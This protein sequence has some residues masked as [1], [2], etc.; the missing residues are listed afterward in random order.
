MGVAPE[1]VLSQVDAFFPEARAIGLLVGPSTSPESEAALTRAAGEVGVTLS[2]VRVSAAREVRGALHQAPALDALWLVPDTD[3]LSAT[4]WRTVLDET[5]RR[6]IP[7]LVDTAVLVRAGGAFAVVPDP[8]AVASAAIGQIERILQGERPSD[9]GVV[10]A[11]GRL[12]AVNNRA[13]DAIDVGFDPLLRD[14]VDLFMQ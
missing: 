13:L 9:L 7:L 5:W 2:V 3:L 11:E 14:F 6:K 4:T 12:V 8:A 1:T 10:T